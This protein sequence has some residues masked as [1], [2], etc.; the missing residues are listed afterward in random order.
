VKF[1]VF[2]LF[3]I[4]AINT[5]SATE[6]AVVDMRAALLQS[7][8]GQEASK[9]PRSQ[10]QAMEARLNQE[11]KSVNELIDAYKRDELTLSQELSTQR[12][13][14]IST[15]QSKV[16]N[17][18]AQMQRKAQSL[19]QAVIKSLLPKGEAALKSLIEEKK[20]DLVLNRQVTIFAAQSVDITAQ[21]VEVLNKGE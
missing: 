18:E 21:L 5:A 19:E 17:M 6:V 16:R 13:K 1:F 20:L 7:N 12:K 9:A 10:I 4:L 14:D 8:A 11:K 2:A 15:A 3:S